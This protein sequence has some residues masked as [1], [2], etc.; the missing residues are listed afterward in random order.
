[1]SMATRNH[2]RTS[3]S[4]SIASLSS[5]S[6]S[7]FSKT[8]VPLSNLPTPPPSSHSQASSRQHTPSSSISPQELL[9]PELLGPSI[10]LTN[11]IPSSTSLLTPSIPLVYSILTRAALPPEIL[12]LAVCILDSL[13]SRFALSWRMCCPLNTPCPPLTLLSSGNDCEQTPHI[14]TVPPELLILSSLILAHKFLDDRSLS[15]TFYARE[16][17]RG[18]WSKEQVNVTQYCI[19]ENLGWR[20][21]GL[22]E[23]RIIGQAIKDMRRAGAQYL[24][25]MQQNDEKE[26]EDWE[27]GKTGRMSCGKA[28]KGIDGMQLTPVETPIDSFHP[29]SRSRKEK[30]GEHFQPSEGRTHLRQEHQYP[31]Y[32]QYLDA[33]F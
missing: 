10:H 7:Y 1:M 33:D 32:T 3:S 4:S 27:E 17:G 24:E 30:G 9:A 21:L 23:G 5:T 8:Y 25:E 2:S 31:T 14:D 22:W 11:L 26:S 18:I 13:N 29:L 28:V 19:L 15:T 12:A 6:S 16:W 20:L